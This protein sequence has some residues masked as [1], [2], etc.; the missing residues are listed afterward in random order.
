VCQV[1]GKPH[2]RGRD[3]QLGTARHSRQQRWGRGL[4]AFDRIAV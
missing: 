3:R 1:G 2:R 4:P